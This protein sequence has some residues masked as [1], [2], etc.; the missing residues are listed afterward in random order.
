MNP[1]AFLPIQFVL[2]SLI[3]WPIVKN[4]YFNIYNN[5]K[6]KE[7]IKR[8]DWLHLRILDRDFVRMVYSNPT[9]QEIS[10]SIFPR[11]HKSMERVLLDNEQLHVDHDRV[12]EDWNPLNV[13]EVDM[14]SVDH[15][16]PKQDERVYL[17]A[18]REKKMVFC[19]IELGRINLFYL[20]CWMYF[21]FDW[22][23]IHRN[24]SNWLDSIRIFIIAK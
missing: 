7:S 22:I 21:V 8:I 12:W 9:H 20:F 1:N 3:P 14:L 13:N 23:D 4:C 6:N 10:N 5:K 11:S 18:N 17:I 16:D 15:T 2:T 19:P 24:T